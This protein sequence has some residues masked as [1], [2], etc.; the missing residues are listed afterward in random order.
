LKQRRI[1]GIVNL[2]EV[3]DP[4]QI[5]ALANDPIVDRFFDTRTSPI[6]WFLLK[7]SL[8]VL[9]FKG[10][11]F[12]TMEPRLCEKR[13]RA[14]DELW[15]KL[16]DQVATVRAGP[17]GLEPLAEWVKGV[18]SE[19]GIGILAQQV[20]GRLFRND[21]TA[22][23]ESWAAALVLVAAPRSS[24][25]AKMCWWFITGKVRRAKGLLAKMVGDDLSAVNAIGIAVHNLAKSLRQMRSL[26][27]D[28]DSRTALSAEVA[29]GKCLRAPGT[30]LAWHALALT[31]GELLLE[32]PLARLESYEESWNE[33]L[34]KYRITRADGLWLSDGTG[35]YPACARDELLD[36]GTSKERR[37]T[38][39]HNTLL[40]LAGIGESLAL[41]ADFLAT[42]NWKSPD[43][44]R[45]DI[46]TALV[47][48]KEVHRAA[49]A[50]GLSTGFHMYLPMATAFED[51]DDDY[52]SREYAPCKEW[53]SRREGYV[54]LDEF[55]P[56]GSRAAIQRDRLT[57]AINKEYSLSSRDPW[58]AIWSRPRGKVAY[59]A[60]AWGMRQGE[61]RNESGEEGTTVTCQTDLLLEVLKKSGCAETGQNEPKMVRHE[62]KL[63]VMK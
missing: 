5:K 33:W 30:Y 44:I 58:S 39:D 15:R 45:V 42:G 52:R 49:V 12:P 21:F 43:G 25:L 50:L 41:G 38:G 55:D 40:K 1:P 22:T 60:E 53:V 9:S 61:G 27:A 23:P 46:S 20:L 34:S 35:R 4:S 3:S 31:A 36:E 19:A 54:K 8:T 13:A 10:R 57:M 32:R 56:Y 59:T 24:N 14:Q 7:R 28:V 11:R 62:L 26:Y 18:G 47:P 2:F 17:I 16:N 29:A 63:K 48:A 6:N 37:P 51:Q